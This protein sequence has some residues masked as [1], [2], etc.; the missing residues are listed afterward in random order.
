MQFLTD[1]YKIVSPSIS[2]LCVKLTLGGPWFF[3]ITPRRRKKAVLGIIDRKGV[4]RLMTAPLLLLLL[5]L[6]LLSLLLPLLL[7]S[8]PLSYIQSCRRVYLRINE[9]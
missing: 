2:F 1:C 8:S 5:L 6:L 4:S 9:R 3:F 7:D